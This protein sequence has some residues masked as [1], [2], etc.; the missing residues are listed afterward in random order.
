[1]SVKK[2]LRN[3]CKSSMMKSDARSAA[4]PARAITAAVFFRRREE[5]RKIAAGIVKPAAVVG[6]VRYVRTV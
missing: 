1:M 6:E 4:A 2:S 5:S 3:W